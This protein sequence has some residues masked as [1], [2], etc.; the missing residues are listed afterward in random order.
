MD[1][2]PGGYLDEPSKQLKIETRSVPNSNTIS[3]RDF[4]KLDRLLREKPNAST[5]SL[6]GIILFTNNK[7]ASWLQMKSSEER[8]QLF[9][10]AK[11]LAPE[12][13]E[14]YRSRRQQLLVDRARILREKQFAI[15]QLQEKRLKEK[16]KVTQ[17][18]MSY[19]LWQTE[20]QVHEGLRRL[21][22]NS[23]KLKALKC[24][25]DFRKKVLEQK[26]P[27]DVFYLSKN[28]KI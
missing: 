7:T 16:E 13:K 21:R 6:E 27:K 28:K 22:S 11:K 15:Q 1:H 17:D 19:G 25:L 2:L 18:L 10:Q 8:E 26:A 24:Q 14:L 5:L 4:A 20:I 3:E 12:F 9:R 23:D